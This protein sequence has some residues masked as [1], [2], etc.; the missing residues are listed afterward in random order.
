MVTAKINRG[1]K[2]HKK[3]TERQY[4]NIYIIIMWGPK[5]RKNKKNKSSR[6]SKKLFARSVDRKTKGL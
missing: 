4:N 5:L 1:F 3:M 6:T 2:V